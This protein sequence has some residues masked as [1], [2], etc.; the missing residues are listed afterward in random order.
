MQGY[1]QRLFGRCT[2]LNLANDSYRS[3]VE[4]VRLLR[5]ATF[6]IKILQRQQ[7]RQ[8]GIALEC[9]LVGFGMELAMLRHEAVIGHVECQPV[10]AQ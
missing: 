2:P 1:Q 5:R 9:Q 3:A 6:R 10:T 4:N 8:I 7:Q